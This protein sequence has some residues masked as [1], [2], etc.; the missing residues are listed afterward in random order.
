M[1][2]GSGAENAG[3]PPKKK[4]KLSEVQQAVASITCNGDTSSSTSGGQGCRCLTA[5]SYLEGKVKRMQVPG[6][7]TAG[8]GEENRYTYI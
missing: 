1:I 2:A 4:V 7:I 6:K 5:P 3:T 8:M